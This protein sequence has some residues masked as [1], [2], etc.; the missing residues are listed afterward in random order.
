MVTDRR[1]ALGTLRVMRS[2]IMQLAIAMGN[3]SGGGHLFS[4]CSPARSEEALVEL[5]LSTEQ[6]RR[7][8][9]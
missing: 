2:H 5:L 4:L 8:K 7:L 9:H 6:A 1:E 3:K